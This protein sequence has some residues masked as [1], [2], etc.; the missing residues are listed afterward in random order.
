MIT[1][2]ARAMRD[3]RSRDSANAR[4]SHAVRGIGGA[5]VALTLL[6]TSACR[7]TEDDVHHWESRT[8]GPKRLQAV[9]F[10][11]KYEIP[12]RV[13]AALSLVKMTSLGN[14]VDA[15]C[16]KPEPLA[17]YDAGRS[18]STIDQTVT[19]LSYL[20]PEERAPIL[21]QLVPSIIKELKQPPPT[22][23]SDQKAP[24]DPSFA[25]K[26]AG[27]AILT[28]DKTVLITDEALAGSLKQ[29]LLEWAMADF[30]RRL[31]NRAQS[32]GMEQ[33]LRYLGPDSVAGLPKL[34]TRDSNH[35]D[36][37]AALIQELGT[38]A[39]KEEASKALV[40]IATYVTS[41]EW[42]KVKTPQLQAANKASKLEPNAAQFSYQLNKF[43]D[44]DFIRVLGS[45]KKV[46]GRAAIDFCLNFAADSKQSPERRQAA[47]AAVEG[48]LDRKNG[49]DV[50][51]ILTIAKS[52]APPIVLDQAFKR[53]GELPRDAVI[54]KLY[55]V[56]QSDKWTTRRAAAG[57]VLK[58]STM[59]DFDEFMSKL[60][61][62]DGSKGFAMPE[63]ITYG[64][65][66]SDL[67][68]GDP[69]EGV[70]KY[71]ASGTPAQRATA[72][73]FYLANGTKDD[74]ATLA[75]YEKDGSKAPVCEA[76]EDCKWICVV[77]TASD[78]KQTE[79]KDIKTLGDYVT[80]CAEPSINDRA[81]KAA[82][83]KDKPKE[84][85]K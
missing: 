4:A 3:T 9:L 48:K 32:Y 66:F 19:T 42:V 18:C 34:M 49:Q 15:R 35:L 71:L 26:D 53:I 82:Q 5:F 78:P 23:Q 56:F 46:G 74:L 20:S 40:G 62:K 25:Y 76:D 29:A 51:R 50:D 2:G 31:E 60:P 10:Y 67:K 83:A 44:E 63:S 37:M 8:H 45:M 73:S 81:A 65:I 1:F 12:L 58:M 79:K 13:E 11:P 41:D 38:D 52:D 77:P 17:D 80:F 68:E 27:Y 43:Q 70:K 57:V 72:V 64:A 61:E 36:K 7:V 22:A 75:P 21:A 28:Y 85:G 55:E 47:L 59:K 14:R 6:A 24:P 16:A 30:D 84:G 33:L 39:T 54:G 69:R